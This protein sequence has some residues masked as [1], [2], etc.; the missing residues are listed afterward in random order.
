MRN[1]LILGSFFLVFQI[2][3]QELNARVKIN[4]DA[5]AN[6]NLTVFKT[7][8]NALNEFV[9]KTKFSNLN[10]KQK[11][12]IECSFFINV[13][14]FDN[15]QFTATLQVQSSRPVFDSQYNTPIFNYNDKDFTFKYTEFEPLIYN[16][17]SADSNLMAVIAFYAN[18]IIAL[19]ADSFSKLGGTEALLSA[20][21][22]V[23][24]CQGIGFKG[25]NQSEGNQN[26][27]FIVNDLLS[28]L[29]EQAR[30][31]SFQ[32]NF[33]G[34]DRMS[35]DIKLGKQ[36][37]KEA[38]I[39]LEVINN[40]RPNSFIARLFFDAKSDEIISIFS[41]GPKIDTANLIESLNRTS[42]SNAIRWSNIKF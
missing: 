15:N 10:F 12:K 34:L 26:R 33:A 23:N 41:G 1:L 17:N 11:E 18:I 42:P 40:A 22:I 30:L 7:L 37:I 13:S 24:T 19:D 9:I 14:A 27:F 36:T 21:E 20:Q 32:Y 2:S 16:P 38:L 25:W 5:I 3:A 35:E 29:F 28:T 6:A 39:N 31:G 4:S 8:E